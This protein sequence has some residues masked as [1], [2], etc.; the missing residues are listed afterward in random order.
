MN[1]SYRFSH[2]ETE[3][4]PKQKKHSETIIYATPN[5][6]QTVIENGA[7]NANAIREQMK[8]VK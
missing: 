1:F 6:H 5:S 8:K 2:C 7:M 4:R 3:T